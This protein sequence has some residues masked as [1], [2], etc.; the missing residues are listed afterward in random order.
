MVLYGFEN[1]AHIAVVLDPES[2]IVIDILNVTVCTYISLML[3]FY[4][5]PFCLEV[6]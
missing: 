2:I 6:H 4:F 3:E 5:I 1:F